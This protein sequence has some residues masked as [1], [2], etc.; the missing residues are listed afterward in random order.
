MG[1]RRETAGKW[2]ENSQETAGKK[3]E[4]S[5]ETSGKQ[6][7][8]GRETVG[9]KLGISWKKA[10]KQLGNRWKKSQ[11]TAGKQLEKRLKNRQKKAWKQLEKSCKKPGKSWQTAASSCQGMAP[12][13]AGHLC[14][15]PKEGE[16]SPEICAPARGESGSQNPPAASPGPRAGLRFPEPAQRG[17]HP[18]GIPC[19]NSKPCPKR[20]PWIPRIPAPPQTGNPCLLQGKGFRGTAS[21]AHPK[22]S[23]IAFGCSKTFLKEFPP[24]KNHSFAQNSPPSSC[25]RPENQSTGKLLKTTGF[26]PCSFQTG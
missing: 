20:I 13:R 21:P 12:S 17:A 15:E 2:L 26:F 8:N 16:L 6:P 23:G 3:V 7:E 10:G 19:R 24:P 18:T 9:K 5:W 25:S 14:R 22:G 4:N 11:K 1:K